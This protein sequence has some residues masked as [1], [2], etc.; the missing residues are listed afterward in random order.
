MGLDEHGMACCFFPA[1]YLRAAASGLLWISENYLD[2][3][4]R[5]SCLKF[6]TIVDLSLNTF[7]L[8][9]GWFFFVLEFY[10]IQILQILKSKCHFCYCEL[11][12]LHRWQREKNKENTLLQSISYFHFQHL[13]F[14]YFSWAALSIDTIRVLWFK[15]V[16][17]AFQVKFI[18]FGHVYSLLPIFLFATEC[19][20]VL[21][22]M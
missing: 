1:P 12:L 10:R 11:R 9:N 13:L 8:E 3:F 14:S 5:K 21:L 7:A 22:A 19:R 2:W 20:L 17:G 15:I 18:L 16:Q 6:F 4:S